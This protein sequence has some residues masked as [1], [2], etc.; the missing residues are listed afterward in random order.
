MPRNEFFTYFISLDAFSRRTPRPKWIVESGD[1]GGG[2]VGKWVRFGLRPVV[3]WSEAQGKH[4]AQVRL[5]TE[6]TSSA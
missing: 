4:N 6:Y 2:K 5:M 3:G 1:D